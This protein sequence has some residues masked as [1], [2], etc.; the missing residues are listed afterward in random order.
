MTSLTEATLIPDG[1]SEFGYSGQ[2]C[3][4]PARVDRDAEW[5]RMLRLRPGLF[6]LPSAGRGSVYNSPGRSA[7]RS[8]GEATGELRLSTV[9]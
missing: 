5:G 1:S 9:L 4:R 3:C 7:S 6:E 2:T 8:D